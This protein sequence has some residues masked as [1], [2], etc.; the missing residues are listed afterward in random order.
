MHVVDTTLF[1][2][3]TSG[4]VKRYLT[5]KQDWLRTHTSHR[6][7]LL[8][9]GTETRLVRGGV[10]TVAGIRLP[11][12]FNYRLPLAVRTWKNML[13]E[14]EPDL[15][16]VGDVFHPAWCARR[17]RDR[18]RALRARLRSGASPSAKPT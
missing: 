7:S 10:S 9:P 8:V 13:F 16:E 14:L 17:D 11:G 6:H 1:Y 4:G 15:I 18:G 3:P 5:A 2:S 12:T